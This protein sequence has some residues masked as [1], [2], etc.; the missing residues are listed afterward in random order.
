MQSNFSF[1]TSNL[2]DCVQL[3]CLDR[4]TSNYFL[5]CLIQRKISAKLGSSHCKGFQF[6]Q[7]WLYIHFTCWHFKFFLKNYF[8][9]MKTY[10][11]SKYAYILSICFLISSSRL[12]RYSRMNSSSNSSSSFSISS[13]NLWSFSFSFSSSS[14]KKHK[15]KLHITIH[16]EM[17]FLQIIKW[18]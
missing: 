14:Y 8:N 12:R 4:K 18:N 2:H 17:K 7:L 15:N 16:I 5:T 6:H 13:W 10:A 3:T 9:F 11:S 1:S